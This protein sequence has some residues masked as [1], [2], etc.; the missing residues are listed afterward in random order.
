MSVA[1]KQIYQCNQ[2]GMI[3]RAT[4]LCRALQD[5]GVSNTITWHQ[6]QHYHVVIIYHVI[7][8]AHMNH[9]IAMY[10]RYIQVDKYNFRCRPSSSRSLESKFKFITWYTRFWIWYTY[11]LRWSI[12]RLYCRRTRRRHKIIENWIGSFWWYCTYSWN[13]ALVFLYSKEK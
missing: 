5:H 6:L 3:P 12:R 10:T 2:H 13:N 11:N 7:N 9:M 1:S 4:T 8:N